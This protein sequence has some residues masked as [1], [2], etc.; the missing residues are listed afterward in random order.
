LNFA[1]GY[2]TEQMLLCE[3]YM[4]VIALHQAGF[5][6]AIA[7]LGTAFTEEQALLL[8]R[9]TKE[10]VLVFDADQAGQ[11]ATERALSILEKTGLKVRV[12]RIPDG[13]DPDEYLKRYGEDGVTKFRNLLDNAATA[14]EYKLF[15][16]SRGLTLDGD[17][18]KVAYLERAAKVIGSL[19]SPVEA[20]VYACRV[21]QQ[22]G[23]S[24]EAVFRAAKSQ[25]KIIQ[26]QR[27][28][29][30]IRQVTKPIR[31]DS[32]NPKRPLYRR[33]ANAEE[34]LLSVL[35]NHPDF[36][37]TVS[38]KVTGSDFLTDFHRKIYEEL[39]G[40]HQEGKG[41]DITL[42]GDRFTGEEIGR[43]VRIQS[44]GTN[45][46][47]SLE[48]CAMYYRIMQ[49][50]VLKEKLRHVDSDSDE[51]YIHKMTELAK[52]KGVTES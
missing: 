9:Y 17:M 43:L 42:L 41:F 21:A 1:K 8:S 29:D 39:V 15:C 50:E 48:E 38:Q 2:G 26:Q 10:L 47:N 51:D 18:D 24:K 34:G 31:T 49:E 4:D 37:P 16:A 5:Q 40:R 44:Q 27:K 14:T 13:K 23:V 32:V 33:A 45:R 20:D 30:E 19:D 35:I 3:G 28:K 22:C 25:N 36:I 46:G 52:N 7:P 12:L 11:K 6:N